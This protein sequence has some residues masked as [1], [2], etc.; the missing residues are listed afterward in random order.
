MN[1][2]RV[3]MAQHNERAAAKPRERGIRNL[4]PN[5]I[6]NR[7]GDGR[8]KA[9]TKVGDK[10]LVTGSIGSRLWN[11]SAIGILNEEGNLLTP[12][13]VL[14]CHW[15][16]HLPI[17]NKNWLEDV[18]KVDELL[19]HRASAINRIREP[20]DVL[21]LVE[22]SNLNY[23][24]ESW[25]LRWNRGEHPTKSE[26]V[27]EVRW[28]NNSS[29]INW[30]S[31]F[32]WAKSVEKNGRL[33]EILVVDGEFDVTA[34]RLKIT[35]P[36]GNLNPPSKLSEDDFR[37]ILEGWEQKIPSGNGFWLPITPDSMPLPQLGVPQ[38]SGI[39][40]AEIEKIWLDSILETKNLSEI[41]EIF[42][43]LLERGLWPRPGFKYGCRWRVYSNE[44]S[45]QH[46]PWLI[47]PNSESPK[48]WNE[49]CLAA[50]LAAGVNKSWLCAIK[51]NEKISFIELCRWSPGKA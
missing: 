12:E 30:T 7:E 10:W 33:A 22:N 11:K 38:A 19:L 23:S 50:R 45:S 35:N 21:V 31:I 37:I 36:R 1:S 43:E 25:A 17:P 6:G 27:S 26:P 39:W 51:I 42:G 48:N 28:V 13:E 3:D 9:P 16:R 14:F 29:E 46:A 20:G 47:V 41:P 44:I 49:A 32:E 15:H 24:P 40:L 4:N 34:Y 8:H 2:L 18:L 5:L